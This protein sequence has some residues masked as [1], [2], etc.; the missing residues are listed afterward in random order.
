[1]SSKIT[2]FIVRPLLEKS[3][4]IKAYRIE[5]TRNGKAYFW[6]G[7]RSHD[8]VSVLIFNVQ[9]KCFVLVKQFRPV[10]YYAK[11]RERCGVSGLTN[12]GSV[13]FDP[14]AVP[15]S[16]GETLE[17]CA[18]LIDGP[19]TE[20]RKVAVEEVFEECGYRITEESLRLINK[21]QSSVGLL[22][23]QMTVFYAEVDESHRVLGAGGGLRDEGEY[24]EIVNWP[25]SDLDL[26]LSPDAERLATSTSLLY[27]LTWFKLNV[28]PH[29]H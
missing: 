14:I 28:L 16:Q 6:D 4:Y 29:I 22:G 20:P 27:S 21:C 15:L 8:S 3:K 12:E 13:T 26:L 23:S 2:S 7:V 24:I 25:I 9:T 19:E 1:M 10:V 5:Y 17:L 18:G 11:V